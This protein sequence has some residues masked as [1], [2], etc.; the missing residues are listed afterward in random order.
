MK[1]IKEAKIDEKKDIG[2]ATC[3]KCE[4]VYSLDL[5]DLYLGSANGEAVKTRATAA[6]CWQCKNCC[7][8]NGDEKGV[9]EKLRA[10][11]VRIAEIKENQRL[12]D[13]P[14]YDDRF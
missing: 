7:V 4:N 2:E 10:D 8:I 11:M 14:A 5:A 1:L 3:K 9:F 12:R 6:I 13:N